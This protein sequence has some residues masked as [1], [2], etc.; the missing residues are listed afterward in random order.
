MVR[1]LSVDHLNI[2]VVD[3]F[4]PF[5]RDIC[6]LVLTNLEFN[7]YIFLNGVVDTT[8]LK[9]IVNPDVEKNRE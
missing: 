1:T 4:K 5:G 7:C 9:E 6:L 2:L 3:S 8:P